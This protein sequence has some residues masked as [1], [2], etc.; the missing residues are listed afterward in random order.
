ME[1]ESPEERGGAKTAENRR[2]VSMSAKASGSFRLGDSLRTPRL[3]VYSPPPARVRG[4]GIAENLRRDGSLGKRNLVM[5]R[6]R[7]KSE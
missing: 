4:A 7:D 2:V 6:Q 5:A 1:N 3:C